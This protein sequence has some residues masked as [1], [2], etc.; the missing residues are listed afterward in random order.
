MQITINT[1]PFFILLFLVAYAHTGAQEKFADSLPQWFAGY[2]V[3]A[4]Q[5]KVFVHTDKDFYVTGEILWFK[6]YAADGYFNKPLNMSK[7]VYA[8]ILSKEQK[9]LLQAKVDMHHSSGSGSFI[10]PNSIASGNYIFRAYTSWMKNFAPEFYFEK[11]ITIVNTL[12]KP[13]WP[14]L[15]DDTEYH[16]TFFPEGGNLVYGLQSKVAFHATNKKGKGINC[17]GFIVT[18]NNDTVANFQTHR[19]GMGN[20]L[21]TPVKGNSYKAVLYAE[22]KPAT[23]EALPRIFDE[24][25]T[26]Q[27]TAKDSSFIT[28]NVSSNTPVANEE[29]YL[30][31][32]TRGIIKA[33]LLKKPSAGNTKFDLALKDLGE[34]ISHLTIFNSKK[35]PV[36][37]RL[38]FKKPLQKLAINAK[39]DKT[40]YNSRQK[41][42]VELNTIYQQ[43]ET[44]L[45]MAVFL[46]DSLQTEMQDDV[47]SYLW[48]ASELKGKIES[49]GYYFTDNGKETNEAA[50]NLMLTQGWR[51]FKWED[52]LENRKPS[53]SFVPEYSGHIINGKITH[54]RNGSPGKNII[55]YLSVP[56]EKFLFAASTAKANGEISFDIKNFY[57]SNEIIVQTNPLTDSTYRI[58]ITNPFSDQPATSVFPGFDIAETN[59][60]RLLTRSLGAQVQNA[61]E[62]VKKMRFLFPEKADTTPFYFQPDK[63]YLL[64]DYT[65][66][67]TMEEVIREYVNEVSL[68][69]NNNKFYYR[70]RNTPYNI[71]F[72]ND[73]LI[74]LDGVPVFDADLFMLFD[75]LKIK[76]MDVVARKYY[77]G[78]LANDGIVSYST[79]D[80]D[81]AGYQL[82]PGALVLEYH[83]LQLQREFYSPVYE[84]TTQQQSRIPDF[85]NLLY[86]SPQVN[87]TG[88]NMN[89]I[90]FYTSDIPGRYIIFIQGI[91]KDGF[92]GSTM[93]SFTVK[94]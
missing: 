82:N 77:L 84:T 17:K 52:I 73:P 56:G 67:I 69:K 74:L 65:R 22:N 68:R 70:V 46:A 14:A 55:A 11:P 85:R 23:V 29:V 83:G 88:N 6:V 13:D 3:Q 72:S 25:Y 1:R 26:M 21:F 49:P 80:G 59:A 58:D 20:F 28:I 50:D 78:P 41:V 30:L 48:L 63:R 54:K 94:K 87:T 71:N 66:F 57:G 91:S 39:T 86:W 34:G 60:D 76:R 81:L 44:D 42:T 45:S 64:D 5:E 18:Q 93:T 8:E 62:P 61:Y 19:F 53:F 51:R 92:A 33:A 31:A 37:E 9:P 35:V 16:V 90:E 75:P 89:K 24:G 38:Y 4:L 2:Q 43:S 36:C 10:L 40:E 27:L 15:D 32:H 79:Y 7:V 12:K 47:L